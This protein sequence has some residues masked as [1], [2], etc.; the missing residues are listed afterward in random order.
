[1]T[2]H[3]SKRHPER[4]EDFPALSQAIFPPAGIRR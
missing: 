1:M 2:T 4:S 3:E